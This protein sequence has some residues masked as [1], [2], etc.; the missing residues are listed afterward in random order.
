MVVP[1]FVN[2]GNSE[3]IPLST[4][5]P[6]GDDTSDNVSV[7]TL[8]AFGRGLDSYVWNDW[9][10]EEAC[11]VDDNLEKVENVT[12][13]PGQ[14]LWVTGSASSQGLQSAGKVNA[15]DVVVQLR[16]GATATGNP[17]P[18]A[19]RLQDIVPEGDDTSDNVSVQTLD[20]FG[21]G[22]ASYVWNDWMFDSACWV[23]DNLE[24]ATGVEYPAGQGLW[25]T[26]STDAQYLRFA[27]PEL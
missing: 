2:I 11:W 7:Q 24:A 20:A 5:V 17:Y 26:G 12:F 15:S 21:R 8:D 18:I 3:S 6:N 13:E 10:F 23:D 25:V 9:M 22:L 4:L 16:S 1:Q 27:A 14:G 19:I